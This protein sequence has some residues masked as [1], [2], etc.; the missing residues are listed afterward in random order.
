MGLTQVDLFGFSLGGGVAQKFVLQAPDLVRRVVLAGTGPAGGG[1][2]DEITKVAVMAY[3]KAALTLKDP[4]AFLFF[5]R[6]PEGKRAAAAYFA[7][8][9]E[10]TDGRDK[11]ISL[12][13]RRA[14]LVAIRAAG[15]QTPDDLSVITQPVFVANGDN[16]LMVASSLSADIARRIPGAQ[17]DDLPELRPRRRVPAP[18]AV[19]ARQC[20]SSSVSRPATYP[21][22]GKVALITGAGRG[23]GAATAEVLVRRGARVALLDIDAE[24]VDARRPPHCP[25]ARPSESTATSPT[26]E[27]MQD[28]VERTVGQFGGIDIAI[29][30]AGVLGRG[31]TLR[32]L[33]PA[34][35]EP[36]DGGQR[37]RRGQH[38]VGHDRGSDP[39]SRVRSWSSARCSRTSTAQRRCPT[40]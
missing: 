37:H 24:A 19:R 12:Q 14:Q 3:L 33:T 2:I 28:A 5:P 17:L 9:K 36:G 34:D 30:N 22:A 32:A 21:L 31:A 1:G 13:A 35:V 23:L 25:M 20:W 18:R 26:S 39:Q 15:Q 8:L 11:R 38:R 29:A 16:D 7:R 4:R 27:S 10:R 6:T 40:P